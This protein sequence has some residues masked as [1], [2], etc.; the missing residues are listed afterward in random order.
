MLGANLFANWLIIN[1]FITALTELGR[2]MSFGFFA[3]MSVIAWVFVFKLAPETKGRELEDIRH[4][5]ENGGKW[6]D[7]KAAPKSQ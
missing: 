3:V 1:F 4:Y 2:A 5:W 7:T 6:D